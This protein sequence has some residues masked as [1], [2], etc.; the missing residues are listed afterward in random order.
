MLGHLFPGLNPLTHTPPSGFQPK[1]HF[2]WGSLTQVLRKI[3]SPVLG[4]HCTGVSPVASL[5]SGDCVP[6]SLQSSPV[7]LDVVEKVHCING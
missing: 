3:R 2:L 7:P 6:S 5:T 1:E 4:S